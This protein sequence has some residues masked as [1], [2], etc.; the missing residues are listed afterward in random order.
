M[1]VTD[2]VVVAFHEYQRTVNT[3]GLRPSH[4]SGA[5]GMGMFPG[6]VPPNDTMLHPNIQFHEII[7]G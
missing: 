3:F 6:I 5:A 1:N 7:R 4:G 2:H